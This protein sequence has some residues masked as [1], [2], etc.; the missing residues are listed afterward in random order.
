MIFELIILLYFVVRLFHHMYFEEAHI[1]WKDPKNV[2]I[3]VITLVCPFH[4]QTTIVLFVYR[5]E[6]D[7][8]KWCCPWNSDQ[9]CTQNS[10]RGWWGSG[11]GGRGWWGSGGRGWWR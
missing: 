6:F 4:F 2:T 8:T 10:A 5:M 3:L 7:K 9:N 11:G 1:F